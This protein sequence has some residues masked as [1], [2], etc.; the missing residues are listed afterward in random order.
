MVKNEK[1]EVPW[2]KWKKQKK[3]KRK[4]MRTGNPAIFITEVTT[5]FIEKLGISFLVPNFVWKKISPKTS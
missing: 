5:I 2:K 1:N 4:K 3:E